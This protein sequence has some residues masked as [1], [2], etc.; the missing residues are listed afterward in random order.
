M[1]DQSHA[2]DRSAFMDRLFKGVENEPGM[3]RVADTP[4]GDP[5]G[6]GINDR[7][8]GTPLVRVTMARNHIGEPFPSCDIGLV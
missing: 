8:M 2:L 6:I 4:A 3:G 5:A 7:V 1:V